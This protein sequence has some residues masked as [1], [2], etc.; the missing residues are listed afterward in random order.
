MQARWTAALAALVLAGGTA[1]ATDKSQDSAIQA[2]LDRVAIGDLLSRYYAN[3]GAERRA[4]HLCL[5]TGIVQD[6]GRQQ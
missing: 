2:A 1:G 6:A 3:F 4:G 5:C